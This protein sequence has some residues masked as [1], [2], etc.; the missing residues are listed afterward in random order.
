MAAVFRTSLQRAQAEVGDS[1]GGSLGDVVEE[2]VA[3]KQS[4]QKAITRWRERARF[5]AVDVAIRAL[6]PRDVRKAAWVNADRFSTVWVSAW[7]NEEFQF[8]NPE[9]REVTT[10]YFGLPSPACESRVGENVANARQ[11]LDPYGA[12][13]TTLT[14]PGDGWRTQHDAIKWRLVQDAREMHVRMRH[15]V[16]GLF[17][18]C[19]PQQGRRQADGLPLRKRQGLVPDFLAHMAVDGPE[20][21]LL[22]ELK[23]LHFGGSTYSDEELRGH[24]VAR[25]ARALPAEYAAKA[26]QVDR[27]F[28]GTPPDALGPVERKLQTYEPVRGIVFGAW[29]EASPDTEKLL[30]AMAQ[31]GAQR[32]WRGMRCAD[33]ARALGVLAWLLRRRWGLTALR[34]NARLKLDRLEY[35]G[36]GALA[37]AQRRTFAA[38]AQAA[39]ARAMAGTLM[40]GPRARAW[41]R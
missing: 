28:S 35:V 30:A 40:S 34:E 5:Q 41:H 11:V 23:T 19:I 17:A 13:L 22:F 15:E 31:T 39:R 20:R 10:W 14:L 4:V 24:A 33:P 25:R 6:P 16:F 3:G 8:S 2:A 9:F 21:P 7:P 29:A 38:E 37:A 27:M 36:R 32:H 18:E 26:R 1:A 12:R